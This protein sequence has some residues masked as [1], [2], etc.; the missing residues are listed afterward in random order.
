MHGRSVFQA[1]E[2]LS[3]GCFG[4]H[5]E[6]QLLQ[7]LKDEPTPEL[8]DLSSLPP[9]DRELLTAMLDGLSNFRNALYRTNA[10]ML[11]S[12]KIKPITEMSER[13]SRQADLDDPDDPGY[14]R[15]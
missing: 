10:N 12:N 8:S 1:H 15:A 2:G 11:F 14:L 7:F 13:L 6:Y 4:D 5:L 9:E 3:A